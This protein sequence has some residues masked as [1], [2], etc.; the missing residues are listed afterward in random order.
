LHRP[1]GQTIVS[2]FYCIFQ[3]FSC[4]V[5][6]GTN[7][8]HGDDEVRRG[9]IHFALLKLLCGTSR[10]NLSQVQKYAVLSQRLPLDINSTLYVPLPSDQVAK[11]QEQISNHMRVCMSIGDGIETT[12]GIAA[13]EPM[14]AEAA[15]IV[16]SDRRGFNLG[17][18]LAEV[19]S[20]YGI[21]SGDRAELLVAAFFTWAR[22]RTVSA[23]PHPQF[24]GQLSRHFSVNELFSSLFSESTFASMSGNTSSLW[25]TEA[26]EEQ[27]FGQVFGK[28][29]MH[30]NHVIKPHEQKVLSLPF[31]LL[32]MA[33]GAAA[34]G[35]NNQP[36]FD[37][38]YPFLYDGYDLD[39]QKLGFVI[40]QVKKN[41]VSEESQAEIFKK[42][43]PFACG[44][45]DSSRLK[46]DFTIPIIRIVFALCTTGST[47]V[48]H[49]TYSSPLEGASYLN[50]H[51]L[52]RFTLYDFWCSG[53][54]PDVIQ[55]VE[56]APERWKALVNKADSWRAFYT[57]ALDPVV[58][59]SQ[60]PGGGSN[61]S[62]Y[63]SWSRPVPGF[64]DLFSP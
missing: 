17:D 1:H 55:P 34:F 63:D 47:G 45:L 53:I 58:L 62:H 60:N 33:R 26:T 3:V 44:L 4:L 37:A 56:E 41:D 15:S 36:G 12:R 52:A 21:N 6:W 35:A 50:D 20:G 32:Y 7:Y 59:R 39:A 25:H 23:K 40:V 51:G 28:A 48:T 38:V 46:G 64:Q 29:S 30:F 57:G 10:K 19:L 11:E 61:Q 2:E 9:L 54:D 43:D 5:R 13:S 42:M 27:T 24:P 16:M 18:T 49:K 14:L 8:D 31:L 22:D